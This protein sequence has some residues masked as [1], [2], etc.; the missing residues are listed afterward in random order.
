MSLAHV[1]IE[2]G[3]N[4][5]NILICDCWILLGAFVFLQQTHFTIFYATIYDYQG[6]LRVIPYIKHATIE[7]ANVKTV[8]IEMNHYDCLNMIVISKLQLFLI[9]HLA[10]LQ[11]QTRKD[12]FQNGKRKILLGL[13]NL[14]HTHSNT[15]HFQEPLEILKRKDVWKKKKVSIQVYLLHRFLLVALLQRFF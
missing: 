10:E 1:L 4:D 7:A 14:N 12:H 11:Y 8:V 6:K 2:Y 9:Y 5:V 3:I 13:S 15:R